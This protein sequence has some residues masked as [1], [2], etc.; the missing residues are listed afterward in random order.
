MNRHFT[1]PQNG[2]SSTIQ[3][4]K[5]N[6]K[7]TNPDGSKVFEANDILV[8]EDWSQVAVDI[9]AQKYFRRKGVPK[10]LKKVQEDGIPEWL[11]K[12]IP[13]TEKLESLKP[14][15]RF[16]G[17]TSALEVFHRLAGCWTYWGYKYK[18]FSD[19]ESAKIFYDE[20]VYMLATQMAAPN[21]PQWFNTGLNWAYGIDGKSQGHYYVDPSTGKLVK[22]TSAY[23]HPQPHACF[24]QS[25]DDDLVNEG[26]IMDLWVRE[27]RLFKYGSG[28]GTNFS[29]L[30]GENEPLSGGGKSS[31]LMSFLKIGDR[32]A[33]AIKSGG[34]TRRA[35]KMVCLD[36]DHPDIE[37]FIDWKVTEEKK[38]ASLV[39]GSMLNNRHLN[40]IMSACYEMEGE[41]RFNPKKNSSL[42]KTI[43]DAKKVLIPDNYIKRVIDLARQG[44]K[45]ILFEELTT[46]WQSDAYNT[47]SGQ[48]SN[49][50]IRLTNEFMAAVEQDQPWNL[51]F[52]TEK[53][54][55][56][57][58]D[59][60]RNLP[61]L[62][63][64]ENSGKR[65][66]MRPGRVQILELNIILRLMNGILVRKTVRSTH[67]TPA[68]NI[69]S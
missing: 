28:T 36:V 38:V 13:D 49:N 5:R 51:Y 63:E 15:D 43:Q 27:A 26:G 9:L 69:C 67:P 55:Q 42:K 58:K 48:N 40:A 46:D 22:S 47:V 30:R 33:G 44:Y 57:W 8:P 23:E 35:A 25:V 52:R 65:F 50:S 21:S 41:D 68:P 31:G 17:E 1:V 39:T 16:G 53:K 64:L 66:P 7:I 10:Y 37:N 60:R 45:E 32:A 54:K 4:T 3:W 18:Y 29:N 6:S 12:S 20:I 11:Q 24:I 2:E 34:T 56:K 62:L 59:V 61:K 19:E 14:E